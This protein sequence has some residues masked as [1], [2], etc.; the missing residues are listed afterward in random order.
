MSAFLLTQWKTPKN[1]QRQLKCIGNVSYE[2][3]SWGSIKS[4]SYKKH[5]WRVSKST[6]IHRILN[7]ANLQGLTGMYYMT[8]DW[9]KVQ[10]RFS[11]SPLRT[12]KVG[13]VGGRQT[14]LFEYV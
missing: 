3:D 10:A 13:S 2:G 8:D 7:N 1:I 11:R 12:R 6:I 9:T 5:K 4:M 14:S